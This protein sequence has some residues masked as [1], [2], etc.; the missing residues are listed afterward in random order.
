MQHS[1]ALKEEQSFVRSIIRVIC[2]QEDP[3][4]FAAPSQA[5]PYREARWPAT[6]WAGETFCRG[7]APR[8]KHARVRR[9]STGGCACSTSLL[10]VLCLAL[11]SYPSN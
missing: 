9:T 10:T 4:Q 3:N 5:F 6:D 7:A 8:G 11:H 2:R 1:G